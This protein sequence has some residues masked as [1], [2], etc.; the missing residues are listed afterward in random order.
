MD[1]KYFSVNV[2][3]DD[4]SIEHFSRVSDFFAYCFCWQFLMGRLSGIS[5][6]SFQLVIQPGAA[7]PEA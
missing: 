2:T 1:K 3:M 6:V 5:A 4:G 7:A